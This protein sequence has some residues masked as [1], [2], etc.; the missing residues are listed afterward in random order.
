MDVSL[1]YSKSLDYV[2]MFWYDGI[3]LTQKFIV[4]TADSICAGAYGRPYHDFDYLE[5]LCCHAERLQE[6]NREGYFMRIVICDD[7]IEDMLKIEKMLIKYMEVSSN[8]DFV[9]EKFSDALQLYQKIQKGELAD[10]YILDM[11]MSEKNGIDIGRQIRKI[12]K[13]NVIIYITSSND[14]ALEAFGVHAVRYLLKPVSED[15]LFEA[16]ESAISYTRVKKDAVYLV[17][18]RDGLV[19]IPYSQIEVIEN[20]SRKLEIQLKNGEVL[21]SIFIRKSFEEEIGD[22]VKDENFLLVHKSYLVNLN[23]IKKL[24]RTEVIMESGKRIPVSKAKTVDVKREYLLFVA[25][26]YR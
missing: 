7:S 13:E 19:S 5:R 22:L 12:G 15:S 25:E 8:T 4:P 18:T 14:Y 23:Y 11:I 20:V 17:K 21:K 24:E 3:M 2:I 9:I 16:L 26:K 1:K 10:I 6:K